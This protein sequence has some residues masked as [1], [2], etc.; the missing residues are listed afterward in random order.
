[1][2]I[3]CDCLFRSFS[4]SDLSTSLCTL[5]SDAEKEEE[6]LPHFFSRRDLDRD[7]TLVNQA[8]L[9]NKTLILIVYPNKF[10]LECLKNR[11]KHVMVAW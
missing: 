7:L 9:N 2:R 3:E 11:N 1:M 4:V 10:N 6:I 5:P 8:S